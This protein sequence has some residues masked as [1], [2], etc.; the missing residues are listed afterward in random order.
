MLTSFQLVRR[1]RYLRS[2]PDWR[3]VSAAAVC[4]VEDLFRSEVIDLPR[5][6]SGEMGRR[7]GMPRDTYVFFTAGSMFLSG[8]SL[9]SASVYG[10]H[11]EGY[12]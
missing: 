12:P 9:V 11:D 4:H 8:G 7:I 5:N 10:H 3:Q 2:R 1:P 6:V